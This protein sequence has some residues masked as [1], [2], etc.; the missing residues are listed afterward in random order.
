LEGDVEKFAK[1]LSDLPH[2]YK[3][4]IAGNHDMTFHPEYYEKNW[5][6]FHSK[7]CVSINK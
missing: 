1:E 7:R 4:V 5:K 3:I 2:K 6:K